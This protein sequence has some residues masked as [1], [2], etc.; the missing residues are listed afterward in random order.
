M[1]KRF[2]KVI[3]TLLLVSNLCIVLTL[4]MILPFM[5]AETNE[6]QSSKIETYDDKKDFTGNDE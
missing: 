5:N 3:S 1:K 6:K 4:T 2:L